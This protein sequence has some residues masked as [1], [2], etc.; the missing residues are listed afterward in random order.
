MKKILSIFTLFL[1]ILGLNNQVQGGEMDMENTKKLVVYFSKTGEQY[2]VGNITEGNT[3]I[4]ANM[5]ATQTGAD[6]FEVKVKNDTYPTTYKAL[7]EVALAEKKASA[8]PE[9]VGDVA[10][11]AEYDVVFIGT[12]NWWADLPMALYTFMEAH[13]WNGKKIAPFVTHE[14]SGLSSIPNKIKNV[15]N[16]EVFDGLSVYGH[17]AQNSRDEAEKEVSAW[18]KKLGF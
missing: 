4:I 6:L 14:G 2:S 1:T 7:T 13:D 3:A 18:L 17:V 9:I 12:P 5:I 11:F 10:N 15:T 8:R 16:T